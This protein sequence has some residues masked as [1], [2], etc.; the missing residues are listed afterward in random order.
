M[1]FA[2]TRRWESLTSS[3][4]LSSPLHGGSVPNLLAPPRSE[5]HGS[6]KKRLS[7]ELLKSLAPDLS[8]LKS[9]VK[10]PSV[11]SVY[12][13]KQTLT[14]KMKWRPS[15]EDNLQVKGCHNRRRGVLCQSSELV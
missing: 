4:T 9:Q 1:T 11:G 13:W 14:D 12:K 5:R 6:L 7:M 2:L 10:W 8:S 3:S 15:S